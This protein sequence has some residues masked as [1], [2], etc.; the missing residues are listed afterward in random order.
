MCSCYFFPLFHTQRTIDCVEVVP[1]KASIGK[2]FK[3]DSK[4]VIEALASLSPEDVLSLE[5]GIKN[6]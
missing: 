3:R 6:G 4:V 5:E 2:Q 1:D